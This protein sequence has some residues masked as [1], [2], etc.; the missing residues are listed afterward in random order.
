MMDFQEAKAC[1]DEFRDDLKETCRLLAFSVGER[2]DI[3]GQGHDLLI[4]QL[5]QLSFEARILSGRIAEEINALHKSSLDFWNETD[6]LMDSI[7]QLWDAIEEASKTE[8]GY[9]QG[10]VAGVEK[11]PGVG[12]III[13]RNT[14]CC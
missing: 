11:I 7:F 5:K 12:T 1:L 14:S 2:Q 9:L 3:F 10:D 13:S 6:V 8:A 4:S